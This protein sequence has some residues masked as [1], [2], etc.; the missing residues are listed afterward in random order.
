MLHRYLRTQSA[1]SGPQGPREA[2]AIYRTIDRR[3]SFSSL[4]RLAGT[5]LIA[6][7]VSGCKPPDRIHS[8]GIDQSW[9]VFAGQTEVRDW[10]K[11]IELSISEP[12]E[13]VLQKDFIELLV[14]DR[15]ADEEVWFPVGYGAKLI[16]LPQ[17][18]DKWQ[19]LTNSMQYSGKRG[20]A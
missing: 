2:S 11:T 9:E 20:H 3:W 14:M 19:E 8:P 16:M 7:L 4:R 18:A 12:S 10:N 1:P 6:V 5:M 17:G 13:G 15:S